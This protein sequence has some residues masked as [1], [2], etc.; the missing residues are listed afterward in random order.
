MI[1]DNNLVGN[2]VTKHATRIYEKLIYLL[3]FYSDLI[4]VTS[5]GYYGYYTSLEHPISY[6]GF[7][8]SFGIRLDTYVH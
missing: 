1:Y 7:Y 6:G 3:E 8:I 2:E 5:K 4:S